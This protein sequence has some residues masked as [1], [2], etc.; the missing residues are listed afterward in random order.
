MKISNR[1]IMI[2]DLY[3]EGHH[4]IYVRQLCNYWLDQ[5]CAGTLSVVL[6]DSIAIQDKELLKF[7]Q[8]QKING[9]FLY[10]IKDPLPFKNEGNIHNLL[11]IDLL[12]GKFAMQY[13]DKLRPTHVLFMLMDHIQV[14]MAFGLRPNYDVV[15]SGILFRQ[16]VHYSALG[17]PAESCKEQIWRLGKNLILRHAMRNRHLHYLFSLDPYAVPHLN[18]LSKHTTCIALPDGYTHTV[19]LKEPSA[20]RTEL[21]IEPNR[22]TALFFG[23]IS[24]RKGIRKVL[25][26]L[27][28]MSPQEQQQLCLLIVGRAP[29]GECIW[30]KKRIS[31]MQLTNAVQIV[32]KNDF[33]PDRYIQDYFRCSDLV[34]VT[35]QRHIGSSHVLIRAA[36][37]GVPVL[38]SNYGLVGKLI[39]TYHLGIAIDTTKTV[40][41]KKALS[42]W[43]KN[44]FFATFNKNHA[45]TFA[46]KNSAKQF[47]YTIFKTLI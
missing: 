42:D 44:G 39:T 1:N 10:I 16:T 46:S 47:A 7:I 17:Y 18:L 21:G 38:G 26:S 28:E 3:S 22:C 19:A 23:V 9:I 43:I 27:D 30:I 5:R 8:K 24:Y 2:F 34:L 15:L 4:A 13:V 37:E 12:H 14:S 32:W 6:S 20:F 31:S 35:Y 11:K 36:A 41:I 29:E 45:R 33:V 25:E 40:I